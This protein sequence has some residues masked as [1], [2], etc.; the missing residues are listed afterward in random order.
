MKTTFTTE[1]APD[2]IDL[3]LGDFGLGA[4]ATGALAAVIMNDEVH[5]GRRESMSQRDDEDRAA[6]PRLA[7]ADVYDPVIEAYKKDVDRTLLCENLKLTFEQ[8]VLKAERIHRS[9]VLVR[10][11]AGQ[12]A[13]AGSAQP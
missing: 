12:G 7:P 8:R 3:A 6:L 13:R 5:P 9:I 4:S 1:S 11:A 2:L 10:G